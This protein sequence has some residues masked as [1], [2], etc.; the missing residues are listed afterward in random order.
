MPR[1]TS[2]PRARVINTSRNTKEDLPRYVPRANFCV[3]GFSFLV[4]SLFSLVFFFCSKKKKKKKKKNRNRN[5]NFSTK[6]RADETKKEKKDKRF[7]F[8]AL[9]RARDTR[10]ERIVVLE[11]Q[12]LS[13]REEE[14]G[15]QQLRQ[16]VKTTTR[17]MSYAEKAKSG[18]KVINK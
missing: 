18:V 15:E 14:E 5:E 8:V 2:A 10:E 11:T 4:L 17:M 3:V 9:S 16:P 12:T 1:S 13:S 7:C 6:R